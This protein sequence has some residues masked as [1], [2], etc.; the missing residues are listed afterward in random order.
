MQYA[1]NTVRLIKWTSLVFALGCLVL[2]SIWVPT[3]SLAPKPEAPVSDPVWTTDNAL[4]DP[5]CMAIETF[6]KKYQPFIPAQIAIKF[7]ADQ[8]REFD[9]GFDPRFLMFGD[10]AQ[11]LIDRT[12]EDTY[13]GPRAYVVAACRNQISR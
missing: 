11:G 6:N 4:A 9:M 3:M 1:K 13:D 7:R 12:W 8:A 5:D 2:L 10:H